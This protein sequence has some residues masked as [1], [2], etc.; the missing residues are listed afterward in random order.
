MELRA[1]NYFVVT[2]EELNITHAAERLCMTQPPL[3]FQLKALEEELGVTLFIR[4]KRRLTLTDEG[5]AFLKRAKQMLELAEKAKS[6]VQEMKSGVS[7]TINIAL[8]E[9]R[10]P[11]L[12]A[13]LVKG[14]SEEY[15]QVRYKLW[16][17]SNDDVFERIEHGLA[18]LA[19]IAAPYDSV[20]LNGINVG[21]EPWVAIMSNSNP[22]A[23]KEGS[24]VS[25]EE[26][27]DYP[28]IV[29][30]RKSRISAIHSWFE[31]VGREPNIICEMANNGEAVA[32]AELNVGISIYPL[33][34][35]T[36]NPLTVSKL[37]APD[38]RTLEYCLV[39]SKKHKPTMVA[40]Q[41]LDFTSDFIAEGNMLDTGFPMPEWDGIVE[42]SGLKP[43]T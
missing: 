28:L 32:L 36:P 40:Q 18:D 6:E 37:I 38:T 27:A 12:A 17:G 11:Y 42:K 34:T 23:R 13:K 5:A 9:G 22:L 2:A 29:P 33:T 24:T 19:I 15:P 14:F 20:G 41:F 39:W 3:S 30:S 8:I 16:T 4:G 1:L 21:W 26:I 43:L 25:L 31:K 10:A 7:G 35:Y